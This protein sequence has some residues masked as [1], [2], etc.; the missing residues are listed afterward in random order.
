MR[1]RRLRTPRLSGEK[2]SINVVA[3]VAEWKHGHILETAR[4][5]LLSASVPS[6]FWAEAVRSDCRLFF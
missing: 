5:L 3:G 6:Q 4:S 1:L 2:K